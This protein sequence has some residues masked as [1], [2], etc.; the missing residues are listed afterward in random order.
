MITDYSLDVVNT[1]QYYK[2]IASNWQSCIYVDGEMYVI[3]RR[4]KK[5]MQ[6]HEG[7]KEKKNEMHHWKHQTKQI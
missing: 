4:K 5:N 1:K 3:K 7:K 2:L 6:Y